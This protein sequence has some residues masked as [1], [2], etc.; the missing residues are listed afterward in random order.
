MVLLNNIIIASL[1][2]IGEHLLS[3]LTFIHFQHVT[4]DGSA[5]QRSRRRNC[6]Y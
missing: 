5:V 6:W 3:L 1:K 2:E 4:I